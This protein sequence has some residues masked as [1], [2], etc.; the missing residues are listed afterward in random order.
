MLTITHTPW[1]ERSH[2][3]I[4]SWRGQPDVERGHDFIK[5]AGEG[6]LLQTELQQNQ[7]ACMSW[8]FN[9]ILSPQ[10]ISGPP[11]GSLPLQ[12]AMISLIG[13]GCAVDRLEVKPQP[14][15]GDLW[16]SGPACLQHGNGPNRMG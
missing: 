2:V 1:G 5:S 12:S 8:H 11:P 13:A 10:G 7:P 9:G 6:K 16:N 3:G 15:A 4:R 14:P